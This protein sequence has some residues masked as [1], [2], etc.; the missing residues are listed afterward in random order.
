MLRLTL[1]TLLAYLDDTLGPAESRLMGQKVAENPT[2]QELVERIKRLT[3]R[4][5]LALPSTSHDGSSSDPNTVAEYLSDALADDRLTQFEQ[6]CLE[7]DVHLADVAACHQILTL[8]LSE[9][10]RVPPTARRR[11]YQ[12][13]KGRESIPGRE[14]GSSIP[15]GGLLADDAGPTGAD[16]ADAAL[17]LGLPAFT[18]GEP[19][20]RRAAKVLAVAGLAV[21]TAAATWFAVPAM[22]RLTVGPGPAVAQ[23]PPP[24]EP[25]AKPAVEIAPLPKPADAKPADPPPPKPADEAQP[26]PVDEPPAKPKAP[27]DDPPA[28]VKPPP[29]AAAAPAPPLTGRVV[30]GRLARPD[31]AVTPLLL[32]RNL[33]T[34]EWERI[35][36]EEGDV[37][38][39]DRLLALP[40]FHAQ[41]RL[42]TDAVVE[43][44]GSLPELLPGPLL[45]SSATLH[46]PAEGF[47]ADLTVHAGRVYLSAR[48]PGGGRVRVR[49]ANQVWDVRLP[50]EKAR[51][52]VEVVPRLA[53]PGGNDPVTVAGVFAVAAGTAGLKTG[54]KD[55]PAVPAGEVYLWN[56]TEGG[57]AA[58]KK[59]DPLPDGRPSP[60]FSSFPMPP[61][62]AAG[63]AAYQA[64]DM[65]SRRLADGAKPQGVAVE[66]AEMKE[67]TLAGLIAART[68]TFYEAALGNL[69]GLV[70]GL[71]DASR[72]G[73]RDAAATGLRAAL[74]ADPGAV[75]AFKQLLLTK[76][77]LPAAAADKA[78]RLLTGFGVADRQSPTS[79]DLAV[80]A[81]TADQV[82]VRE[83]GRFAL[84]E[85]LDPESR[86]NRLLSGFDAGAPAE[87]RA[88]GAQAWRRRIEEIKRKPAGV[89]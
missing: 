35:P 12:L 86:G 31:A 9:P 27:V 29:P 77:R 4:R 47:D 37:S 84:L 70:D 11:M 64:R 54:A 17:L 78:I 79:L 71:S 72:P 39:A 81:L 33:N 75:P 21:A 59:L 83:L 45:W 25:P 61:D 15:V 85:D 32:H 46:P 76:A 62:P 26:K 49:F 48:K 40:G 66:L 58:P 44:W 56:T 34:D 73:V 55:F 23:G 74:A 19:V 16:D 13:V 5:T 10:V 65:L 1:R 51:V 67:T 3:R 68:A 41:V 36:P 53:P 43:L 28:P 2:A 14:P 18:R 50:D 30:A 88:A 80:T 69:S 89:K 6:I 52:A 87:V 7:S 60:Y 22:P 38:T 63:A 57:L 24:S 82:P 42:A 8:V 20:G